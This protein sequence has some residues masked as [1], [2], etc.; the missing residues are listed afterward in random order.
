MQWVEE[1]QEIPS[2]SPATARHSTVAPWYQQQHHQPDSGSGQWWWFA[3]LRQ[4]RPLC[5]A[6]AGRYCDVRP[7]SSHHCLHWTGWAESKQSSSHQ[8]QHYIRATNVGSRRFDSHSP[9]N[10]HSFEALTSIPSTGT[11]T[12]T[13][14]YPGVGGTR[15]EAR[16]LLGLRKLTQGMKV[17]FTMAIIRFKWLSKMKSRWESL[18]Y[19]HNDLQ[20]GGMQLKLVKIFLCQT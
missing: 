8:H 2:C 4:L 7:I 3:S 19:L 16:L 1:W 18:G 14:I 10:L 5:C 13:C 12:V 11:A 17:M 6:A 20:C 9:Y 15:I